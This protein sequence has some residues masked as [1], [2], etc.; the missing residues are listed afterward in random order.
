M[1]QY[2]TKLPAQP[3]KPRSGGISFQELLDDEIVPVPDSLR[4]STD[5]FLGSEDIAMS[6]Y[7]SQEFHDLE[8][9]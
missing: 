7:T 1:S 4:S 3:D 9:E 2:K 8:V 6:R 5:T